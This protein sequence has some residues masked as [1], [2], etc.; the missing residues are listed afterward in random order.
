MISHSKQLPWQL[1]PALGVISDRGLY[2]ANRSSCSNSPGYLSSSLLPHVVLIL[3]VK[4][5]CRIWP[6]VLKTQQWAALAP[7]TNFLSRLSLC[8]AK[9]ESNCSCPTCMIWI[10]QR[11]GFWVGYLKLMFCLFS[12]RIQCQFSMGDHHVL[13]PT[14]CVG[15]IVQEELE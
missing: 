3:S 1:L 4:P 14:F 15:I 8:V 9:S 11:F 6:E 7:L 10:A 13:H 12:R 2:L 5:N